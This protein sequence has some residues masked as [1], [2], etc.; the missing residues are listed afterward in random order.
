MKNKDKKYTGN[1][2]PRKQIKFSDPEFREAHREAVKESIKEQRKLLEQHRPRWYDKRGNLLITASHDEDFKEWRRQMSIVDGLLSD[3]KYKVVNQETLWW[4]GR[5][6]T[7]WLG[8]DHRMDLTGKSNL[9]PLI[10][11]TMLFKPRSVNEMDMMRYSTE[12]EAQEGHKALKKQWSNP[13]FLI[14]YL[15]ENHKEKRARE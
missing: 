4:G 3:F 6:S 8:L 14:K 9:A 1:K 11:E 12:Q 15:W 10:F 7:V 13:L 5:L 2:K